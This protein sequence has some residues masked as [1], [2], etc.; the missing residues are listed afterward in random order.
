MLIV[1]LQKDISDEARKET[2]RQLRALQGVLSAKFNSHTRF[3]DGNSELKAI[4][5]SFNATEPKEKIAMKEKVKKVPG[6]RDAWIS[7]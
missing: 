1:T 5:V 3:Y 7:Y 4:W 6:V 2:A